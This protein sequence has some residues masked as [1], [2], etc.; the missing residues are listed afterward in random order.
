M[1][2]PRKNISMSEEDI[3]KLK[4]IAKEEHRPVSSQI[5]HMLEFYLENKN[6]K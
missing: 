5:K 6:K 4:K 3:Q 1:N 2:M